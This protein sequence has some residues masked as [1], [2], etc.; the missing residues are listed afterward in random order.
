MSQ[1]DRIIAFENG[2]LTD[3]QIV[4]L[5]QELIDSGIAWNLQGT[6]GRMAM[7]LISNGFCTMPVN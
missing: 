5:F 6:Y 4:E 7:S 2:D 1:L 3:E